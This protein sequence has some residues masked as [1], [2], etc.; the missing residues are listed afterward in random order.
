MLA[1][2]TIPLVVFI[3]VGGVW[4]DRLPRQRLM[5]TSDLVHFTSQALM[6]VLLVTGSAEYPGS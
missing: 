2:R 1:A 3:L 5:V 4:A 6:A